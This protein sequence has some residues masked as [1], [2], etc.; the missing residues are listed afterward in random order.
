MSDIYIERELLQEFKLL[1]VKQRFPHW[2]FVKESEESAY[3]EGWEVPKGDSSTYLLRL[4]FHPQLLEARPS[5]Y[6]WEPVTLARV[7]S[8]TINEITGHNTHTWSNGP[9]GRVQICWGAN[10]DATASF[11]LPILNGLIWLLAYS[12]HLKTGRSIADC[13]DTDWLKGY[14]IYLQTGRPIADCLPK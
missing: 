3:L 12:A 2:Q 13:S 1:H 14:L 11:V 9:G 10:W 5:L 4:C 8:G 7:P 6:V